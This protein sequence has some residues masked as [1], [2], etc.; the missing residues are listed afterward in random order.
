[1]VSRLT[2][3]PFKVLPS[4]PMGL[5]RFNLQIAAALGKL[6]FK[7][8]GGKPPKFEKDSVK[9]FGVDYVCDNT[10]LKSTG[11]QF[12]YPDFEKGLAATL[13]WYREHFGL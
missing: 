6:R 1:M 2:G 10:K 9:Y 11:F 4:M 13:P 3:K 5:V 7:M 8:F 12:E